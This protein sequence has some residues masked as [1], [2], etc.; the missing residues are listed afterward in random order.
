MC[1]IVLQHHLSDF[2][3]QRGRL[4]LHDLVQRALGTPQELLAHGKILLHPGRRLSAQLRRAHPVERQ[5]DDLVKNLLM[6]A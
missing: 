5:S 3:K 2:L 1:D 6:L 4:T